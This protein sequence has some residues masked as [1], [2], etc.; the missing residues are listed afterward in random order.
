MLNAQTSSNIVI[1]TAD[2]EGSSSSKE[3]TQLQIS[4]SATNNIQQST[5]STRDI[6]DATTTK[7][8]KW[9]YMQLLRN[10]QYTW[11]PKILLHNVDAYEKA[12]I[13]KIFNKM[14]NQPKQSKKQA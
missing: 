3:A 13:A 10:V 8:N 4:Q 6:T 2:E 14:T 1:D 9:E 5:T 11:I 7:S 12:R